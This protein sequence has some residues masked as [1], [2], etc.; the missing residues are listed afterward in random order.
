[1]DPGTVYDFEWDPANALHNARKYGVTFGQAATVFL[2]P[3]AH[4]FGSQGHQA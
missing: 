4:H 1:M 3:S 2:D